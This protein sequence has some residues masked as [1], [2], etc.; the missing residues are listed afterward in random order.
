MRKII[1][2]ITD[3]HLGDTTPAQFGIDAR[4]NLAH[5]LDDIALQNIDSLVFGGDITASSEYE[6]FF[7]RLQHY[8]LDFKAVLGNHDDFTEAVKY[9]KQ[10]SKSGNALYYSEEDSHYK[11]LYLDSSSSTI[12][13]NQLSWLKHQLGCSKKIIIFI[14]HPI[15][16]FNT[17][18][19]NI[20]PLKNRESLEALLQQA[21]NN[22]YVFCGH[23]HM[24][25]ARTHGN[26]T[27][28]VTP[29]TSFQVKKE[30]QKIDIY[31][32]AFGYR[33]I[34]LTSH[35]VSAQLHLNKNGSFGPANG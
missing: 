25:D 14:H 4:K 23:Y 28:F 16:G 7:S 20:Y 27:Q 1:A 26:I 2:H 32:G 29:A 34:T 10:P 15:I 5:V 19:D 9:F 18:M 11:Y 13:D 3:T 24:P 21:Y 6:W 8:C 30:S 35:S 17:G 12:D 31:N 33:L 22:V